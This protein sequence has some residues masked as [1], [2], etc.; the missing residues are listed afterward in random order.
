MLVLP[1]AFAWVPV[2]GLGGFLAGLIGGYLSGS[3]GRALVSV[4]V[5]FVV[6]TAVIVAIGLHYSL[7]V[8]GSVVAGVV[9]VLLVLHDLALLAGAL[10]GGFMRSTAT[11]PPPADPWRPRV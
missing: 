8:V 11:R 3:P 9:L 2:P 6:I 10:V 7:P 4:L 5:P 1:F